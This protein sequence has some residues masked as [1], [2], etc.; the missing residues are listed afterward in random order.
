M[1]EYTPRRA[2]QRWLKGAPDYV[3]DV[4]DDK[5]SADRY[6]VIFG[7]QFMNKAGNGTY[8]LSYLGMSEK[9]THPQGFSQWGE[10]SRIQ[11]VGYRNRCKHQRIRWVD[12]PENVRQHVI[13]LVEE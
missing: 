2:S 3:L 1:A 10:F 4:F 9:P 8:F 13:N 6:T 5:K 11:C 12:L 7:K